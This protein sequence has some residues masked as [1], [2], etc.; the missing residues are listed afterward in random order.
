MDAVRV[1]PADEPERQARILQ[2]S[3][4]SYLLNDSVFDPDLLDPAAPRHDNVHWLANP[5]QTLFAVISGR[6]VSAS[7]DHAHCAEWHSW[8]A[9]LADVAVDRHRRG[10]AASN[11]QHGDANYLYADGRVENIAAG[12]WKSRYFDRGINP[13]AV[14]E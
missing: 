9:M 3:A 13:G 11:R 2:Q 7:W 6:P 5:A 8:A 10:A 1:C 12:D 4:T 14:P